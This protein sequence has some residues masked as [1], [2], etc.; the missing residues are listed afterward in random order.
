MTINGLQVNDFKGSYYYLSEFHVPKSNFSV[1]QM[2]IF[3]RKTRKNEKK[4]QIFVKVVHNTP[5]KWC[6]EKT[7][8]SALQKRQ[9]L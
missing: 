9:A 1:W 8:L 7:T 5:K 4:L 2:S 6:K 3:S